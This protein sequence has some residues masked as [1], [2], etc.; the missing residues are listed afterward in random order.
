M[1]EEL[2]D[3]LESPGWKVIAAALQERKTRHILELTRGSEAS[4]ERLRYLQASISEINF[5]LDWPERMI[6]EARAKLARA[7]A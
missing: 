6:E 3:L 5:L 4:L 7:S 1:L 2:Q